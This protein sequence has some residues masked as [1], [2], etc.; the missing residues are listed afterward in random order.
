ML[1]HG[2]LLFGLLCLQTSVF[3]FKGQGGPASPTW[4]QQ[5]ARKLQS[6]PDDCSQLLSVSRVS[7]PCSPLRPFKSRRAP[8]TRCIQRTVLSNRGVWV[9]LRGAGS[10]AR[11]SLW[12]PSHSGYSEIL[13]LRKRC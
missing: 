13:I 12:V 6:S 3:L 7:S 10:W 5:N 2:I 11:L 9:V 4:E 1:K 8:G